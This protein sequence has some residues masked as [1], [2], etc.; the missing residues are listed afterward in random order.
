V[1]TLEEQYQRLL[2]IYP[3]E[4][5]RQRGDEILATLLESAE[6]GRTRPAW[7][8]TVDLVG[9]ALRLRLAIGDQQPLGR[10]F[11]LVGPGQLFLASLMSVIAIV[12]GEWG[13]FAR[14]PWV[15]PGHMGPFFTA[16][17]IVYFAWVAAGLSLLIDRPRLSRGLV[18]LS[19]ALTALLVPIGHAFGLGR[20]AMF[21]LLFLVALAIPYVAVPHQGN[22][23]HAPGNARKVLLA[24]PLVPAALVA[25]QVGRSP[26]GTGPGLAFY[27]IAFDNIG[28]WVMW[29]MVAAIA[30]A[31]VGMAL[32]RRQLG[33]TLALLSLPWFVLWFGSHFSTYAS[34]RDATWAFAVFAALLMI[35]T[36]F[37]TTV[38]RMV[39]EEA[40]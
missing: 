4:Y 20:P 17:P 9:H 7:G 2:Q 27:R 16:G 33:A 12:F 25:T 29:G 15:P 22:V 19:M 13:P 23:W 24:A 1:T 30:L 28:P 21:Y 10:L 6:E 11:G 40:G 35:L 39:P 8:D 32:G 31:L 38:R 3:T 5:R 14:W 36:K 26:F 37:A 34:P 18:A